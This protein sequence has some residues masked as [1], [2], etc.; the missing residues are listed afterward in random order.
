MPDQYV[1]TKEDARKIASAKNRRELNKAISDIFPGLDLTEVICGDVVYDTFS[2]KH[3]IVAHAGGEFMYFLLDV[4]TFYPWSGNDNTS[5]W[6]AIMLKRTERR[7]SRNGKR[8][9][10]IEIPSQFVLR[11]RYTLEL[12]SVV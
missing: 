8:R 2:K 12:C 7:I 1:V 3:F 11:E 4:E 10:V 6:R 5:P 9:F